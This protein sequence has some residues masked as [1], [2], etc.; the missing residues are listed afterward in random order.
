VVS[1]ETGF[2]RVTESDAVGTF[3]VSSLDPGSYKLTASKDGFK[4][5]AR[6]DVQVA[7]GAS[8]RADFPLQVGSVFDTITVRGTA[9]LLNESDAST[10]AGFQAGEIARLPLNGGGLLDLIELVPG[11]I[12]VPATRGEPGQFTA[13][14]QRP[15][16]NYFT[17]DGAS[18]NTGIAAGGLP[19]QASGG[20]LPATTAFGSLDSLISLGA[21]EEVRAQTSTTV[22]QFGRM[23][24]ANIGVTSQ[25]GSNVLHGETMYQIRNELLSSNDWFANRAGLGQAPERLNEAMQTIGGPIQR[26]KTFFFLSYQR[27]GLR[28]P[29]IDTRAVP[30]L[31]ARLTAGAW[32]QAAVSLFPLPNQGAL[33]PGVGQWTGGT[34]EPATLNAGSARVDRAAGSH[35]NFF[36]RYS[37]APSTNQFG[38]VAVNQLNL[39]SQTLTLGLTVRPIARLTLDARVNESQTSVDSA[40]RDAAAGDSAT[41]ALEPLAFALSLNM[42][43][44]SCNTLVRFTIDGVGQLVSGSEGLYRQRQFQTVDTVAL[45]LGSHSLGFGADFRRVTAIRRAADATAI[46]ADGATDLSNTSNLWRDQSPSVSQSTELTEYSLWAQDTWQVSSRL[47]VAAGL[48]WEFSPPPDYAGSI[49]VYD[50]ASGS[51]VSGSPPL[52]PASYR[53]LAPRLGAA[54]RVTNDGRTVLRAG[55]GLYYDS[56]LSIAT[57]ILDGVG[58]S[59]VLLQS[60]VHAPFSFI[61][62]YGFMPNLKLPQ[63]RQWN[64]SLERALSAH[65]VV[66]VGYVGSSGRELIR[67]ETDGPGSGPNAWFALTTNNGFSNYQALQFQYRRRLASNLQAMASYSWSHSI[68]NDSSDAA[69]LWAGPGSPAANDAGSS[70]FDLRHSFTASVSY[71]FARGPLKRWRAEAIFRARS[72]FPVTVLE[73]EQYTGIAFINSFRPNFLGGNP[74]WIADASAPGGERLNPAAFA[75]VATGVQGNLGRNSIAGFGMSQVDAAIGRE[76]RWR[77]RFSLD[78]RLDAFNA[79]NHAN[80]GDPVKYMDSPLFGQSTSMLNL[81]LGTGSPGSGLA[82]LFESGGPRMFQGTV[83]FRF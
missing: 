7:A 45:R 27:M 75:T 29:F 32:S 14:G 26:D 15:N 69:L 55:A 38:N 81:S 50:P 80:F 58:L 66:S 49:N 9:P 16:A 52:W 57:D 47:T 70:D 72:G 39:R 53:D 3:Q 76:F 2:R 1:Q 24:G 77:D 11:V 33:A 22:A 41:C 82:P 43:G 30:T 25:S 18:A 67:L 79:L 61:F 63:V 54:F 71:Q 83:R 13:T 62:Q 51:V 21:V 10:G 65:D 4:A 56:S 40:W 60:G 31:D 8:T 35:V 78:L 48:R 19:A 5:F 68:D 73:S 36:G 42:Y 64:V 23:P 17:I 37:D 74:V 6:F 34:D 59:S 28:E 12:V 44:L 20:T 46:I